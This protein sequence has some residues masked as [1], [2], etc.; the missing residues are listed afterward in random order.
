[1]KKI[2][3]SLFLTTFSVQAQLLEG[4][5]HVMNPDGTCNYMQEQ[6]GDQGLGMGLKLGDLKLRP[7]YRSERPP[8]VID[9]EPPIVEPEEPAPEEPNPTWVTNVQYYGTQATQQRIA[10]YNIM[11]EMV[12]RVMNENGGNTA[13]NKFRQRVLAYD[14]PYTVNRF[15][16]ASGSGPHAKS[17]DQI[18]Q[19]HWDGNETRP[20]ETLV[21]NEADLEIEFY[22]AN[23][24]TVGYTYATSK[25]VWVN[26]KFYDT[27]KPS[28]AAG[29]FYHEWSHKLGYG[30]ETN[31][32]SYRPYTVPYG[33]GYIM[34]DLC[35]PLNAEYGY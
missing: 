28:Q 25:R 34:R 8:T 24:S 5:V 2:F 29:N 22:Y 6:K 3:L 12:E 32:S 11:R 33:I 26:T 7:G 16:A 18:Y 21:D 30:H 27:Y 15:V 10:K 9:P 17:N 23:N 35:T 31:S 14:S 4:P 20:T 13:T 19:H 1:M